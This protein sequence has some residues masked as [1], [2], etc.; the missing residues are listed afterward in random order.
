MNPNKPKII[1]LPNAPSTGQINRLRH[2]IHNISVMILDYCEW[3]MYENLP[4]EDAVSM[5]RDLAMVLV[6]MFEGRD[7]NQIN[8]LLH[9]VADAIT[10]K[11]TYKERM[12]L[13]SKIR[14]HIA[15]NEAYTQ[16][17]GE[18]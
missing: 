4:A 10:T 9:E 5:I 16:S 12:A 17:L 1:Q 6:S 3:S 13:R 11:A 7:A 15:R 2:P 14:D 8:H 18:I